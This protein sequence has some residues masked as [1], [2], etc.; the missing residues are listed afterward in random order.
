MYSELNSRIAGNS[1]IHA[2]LAGDSNGKNWSRL[3]NYFTHLIDDC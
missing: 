2:V 1:I 3:F